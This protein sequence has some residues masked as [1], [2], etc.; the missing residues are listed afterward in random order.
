[1]ESVV[2]P[3]MLVFLTHWF[4]KRERSRANTL[5]ILGNPLT[6]TVV[7]VVSGF[8]VDFFD[9]HSVY[10]LRGWQMMFVVEGFPSIIWAAV[11]WFMAE[12][13]PADANW[14]TTVEAQAV[15]QTLDDEQR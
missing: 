10:G 4:T 2:F 8:L 3:G 14:L 15:Q 13:W 12:D 6:M 1:V 5:L 7:S 9:R 11:W